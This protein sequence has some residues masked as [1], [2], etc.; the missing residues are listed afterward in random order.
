MFGTG[1]QYIAAFTLTLTLLAGGG[2]AQA[3]TAA[4]METQGGTSA[5][6]GFVQFCRDNPSDC[7]GSASRAPV[8]TLTKARWAELIAVNDQINRAVTPMT[9]QELYGVVEWWTYPQNG[10]GDCE[11]Y[12]VAK[13][14]ALIARGWPENALLI[15]VVRDEKGDG[16]AVLTAVTDKG[17]MI[18]DNQNPQVLPWW[19]TP[20]LYVKR[21]S[22]LNAARWEMIA[23]RRVDTVAGLRR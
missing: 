23:D 21:Q 11:D 17:D 7:R 2:V 14:K 16:H 10:R 8:V 20:Y 19:R 6:M 9:D 1:R 15:T 13:R 18:L 5:P 22:G 12:V 4:S 3:D